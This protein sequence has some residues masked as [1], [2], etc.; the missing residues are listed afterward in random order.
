MDRWYA[1]KVFIRVVEA[2]S[3]VN[4][5][6]KLELSTTATSRLVA[7]LESHLGTRLLQRTTR[8]LHLTESGQR[9]FERARQLLTD[10]EEA[11]AEAGEGTQKP[12]GL[13]RVSVPASFGILHLASLLPVYRRQ[14]PDVMLEVFAS[15]RMVDLVNDGFDLA[16]RLST[17][18]HP[19]Q[20]GRKLAPIHLVVCASP[21]YLAT[22]G[23]PEAPSDLSKHNCLTHPNGLWAEKWHFEGRDGHIE[24]P[25]RG[26]FRADN[27]ELLRAAALAGE[28][29]IFEPTFIVGGDLASGALVPLLRDWRVPEGSAMAVYPTRR[30]LSAKVRTFIEFLQNAFE[31]A[32]SW[33]AWMR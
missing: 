25:V 9:Y 8:R 4:A 30:F 2:G 3:F 29:I 12:H 15:D 13:L 33:D 22:H 10:L 11:E 16:I 19:T 21:A 17:H 24:V 1:M 6:E 14:Y 18:H 32:P 20:V 23:M 31:K 26:K 5:A 7:D 27:G 28:G